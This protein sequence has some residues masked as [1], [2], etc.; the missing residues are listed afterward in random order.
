[1]SSCTHLN[2]KKAWCIIEELQNNSD[3][4][5]F[6]FMN[7]QNPKIIKLSSKNPRKIRISILSDFYVYGDKIETY[8]S[9]DLL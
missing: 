8:I 9:P 1:M 4:F 2:H 5:Y 7:L 3:C 6:S